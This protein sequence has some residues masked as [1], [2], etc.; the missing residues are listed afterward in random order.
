MN[1]NRKT[2]LPVL[3]LPHE[4]V[5]KLYVDDTPR[6]IYHG[7][8]PNL[9]SF[10]SAKKND[11]FGFIVTASSYINDSFHPVHA[12]DGLCRSGAEGEWKTSGEIQN[13]WIQIQ[14]PGLVRLCRIALR[15]K[16]SNT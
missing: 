5:N 13:F 4:A 2:N 10:G 3:T 1:S 6:K 9:R 16:D 14:C 8:V 12:F 15:S 11:K 7:Y